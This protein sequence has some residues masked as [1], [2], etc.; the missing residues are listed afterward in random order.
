MPTDK[1]KLTRKNFSYY[2]RVMNERT[3]VL[4]GQ[5]GDISSGG[6]R[7]ESDKPIAVGETFDLRIDQTGEISPKGYITFSARTRWCQKDPYDPTIYNVGFQIIDM[8]PADYDIFVQM[9]NTYG[10]QKQIHHK[11][12]TEYIW[13]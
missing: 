3:G 7:L 6:F 10:V 13:G 12:N 2:M 8:T 9:F 1:R 11:T 4:V 5:L